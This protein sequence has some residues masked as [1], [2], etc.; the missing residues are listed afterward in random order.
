MSAIEEERALAIAAA[1]AEADNKCAEAEDRYKKALLKQQADS[2]VGEV[3]ES[4]LVRVSSDISTP[5]KTLADNE[6]ED[7][8][9]VLAEWQKQLL[10]GQKQ[11]AEGQKQLAEGQK[12]LLDGQKQ[13]A[14]GQTQ[15]MSLLADRT[16]C[17]PK[18]NAPKGAD[19]SILGKR[20]TPDSIPRKG[21]MSLANG[22]LLSDAIQ[23]LGSKFYLKNPFVKRDTPDFAQKT[24]S[25]QNEEA[26]AIFRGERCNTEGKAKSS[27]YFMARHTG[28]PCPIDPISCKHAVAKPGR[29]IFL[30]HVDGCWFV[31]CGN[32]CS[33]STGKR[34][35]KL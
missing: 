33:T 34:S 12:Q 7:R 21:N 20:A 23:K 4:I 14:K 2:A 9:K 28:E 32:G 19:S 31:G 25:D 17:T 29:Q 24:Q 10:E 26:E 22:E 1:K 15:I 13:L 27:C 30:S 11:L 18:A 8:L 3:I 6:A 16:I 5:V 35:R